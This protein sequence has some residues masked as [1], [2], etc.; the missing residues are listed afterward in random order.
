MRNFTG[1]DA[2]PACRK[3]TSL[4]LSLW[5]LSIVHARLFRACAKG[6]LPHFRARFKN[7]LIISVF[8]TLLAIRFLIIETNNR[9]IASLVIE[10]VAQTATVSIEHIAVLRE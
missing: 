7:G 3:P 5:H 4:S 1:F 2:V 8:L 10:I 6:K 9:L